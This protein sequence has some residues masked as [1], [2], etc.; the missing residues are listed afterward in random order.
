MIYS[1]CLVRFLNM[2]LRKKEIVVIIKIWPIMMES[3]KILFIL[4]Y[5]REKIDKQSEPYSLI[6]MEIEM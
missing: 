3:F 6:F 2:C 1:F 5:K 4:I